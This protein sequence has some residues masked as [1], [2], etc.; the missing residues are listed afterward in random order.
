M[1]L[2]FGVWCSGLWGYMPEI[3]CQ[4]HYVCIVFG[5]TMCPHYGMVINPIFIGIYSPIV[6]I[7]YI[8]ILFVHMLTY[9]LCISFVYTVVYHKLMFM[10]C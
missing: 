9:Y 4:C 1:C 10:N 6:Y 8:Y 5:V 2:G 7:Y 3:G